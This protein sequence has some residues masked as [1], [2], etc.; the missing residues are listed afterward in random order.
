M[1]QRQ[2][3]GVASIALAQRV[4]TMLLAQSLDLP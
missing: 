3:R 4:R 2:R 1:V